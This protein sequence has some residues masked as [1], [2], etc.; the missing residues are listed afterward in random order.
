MDIFIPIETRD[1]EIVDEKEWE[2][3]WKGYEE[4]ML[5]T[6]CVRYCHLPAVWGG[7]C[8]QHLEE[9]A[10]TMDS[11]DWYERGVLAA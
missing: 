1:E 3:F 2:E 4:E 9:Y 8:E 11:S 7:L 5:D 10:K 6:C